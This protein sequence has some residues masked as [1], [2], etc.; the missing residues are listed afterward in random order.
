MQAMGCDAC[1]CLPVLRLMGPH[2]CQGPQCCCSTAPGVLCCTV[3]KTYSTRK[4]RERGK[5]R[6]GR[7]GVTSNQ[8]QSLKETMWEEGCVEAAHVLS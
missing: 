1:V 6:E 2:E 8:G 5:R 7:R 3:V 4:K